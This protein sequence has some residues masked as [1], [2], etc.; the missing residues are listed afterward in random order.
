MS[1]KGPRKMRMT[2]QQTKAVKQSTKAVKEHAKKEYRS[3]KP[4]GIVFGGHRASY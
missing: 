3:W 2:R 1:E 4:D